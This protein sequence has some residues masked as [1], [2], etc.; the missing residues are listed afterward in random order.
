VQRDVDVDRIAMLVLCLAKADSAV[1]D[2][3]AAEA[4]RAGDKAAEG[5]LK[6]LITSE[7]QMIESRRGDSALSSFQGRKKRSEQMDDSGCSVARRC[8][9]FRARA[10]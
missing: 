6:G 1:S 4:R 9:V 5:R 2:V 10:L 8:S 3:L 7:M